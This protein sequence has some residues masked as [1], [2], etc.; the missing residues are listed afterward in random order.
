MDLKRIFFNIKMEERNKLRVYIYIIFLE[1]YVV[2]KLI[3]II[4]F[5]EKLTNIHD[6]YNIKNNKK[7]FLE[8]YVII[9][10]PEIEFY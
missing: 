5:R 9:L 8:N 3:L 6:N 7:K 4:I 2:F 10:S 1:N